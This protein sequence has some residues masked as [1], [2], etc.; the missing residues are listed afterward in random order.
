MFLL[1]A[2]AQPCREPKSGSLAE[3]AL[4]PDLAAHHLRQFLRNGESEARAAVSSR[5]G[6][7]GLLEALE[8]LG[9]LLFRDADAGILDL[10][11]SSTSVSDSALTWM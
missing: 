8:Q 5:Y 3:F 1:P 10:K 9:F 11:N 7:V 6:A 2:L 4:D